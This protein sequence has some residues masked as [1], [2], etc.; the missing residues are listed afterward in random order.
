MGVITKIG[1]KEV[2]ELFPSFSFIKLTLTTE[3]LI[4][5]TYIVEDKC[6]KYIL[7]K[8]ENK[9]EL[10]IQTHLQL[11]KKLSLHNITVPQLI[12]QSYPWFL[13]NYIDGEH[14]TQINYFNLQQIAICIKKIHK[15]TR[16]YS[17]N[18]HIFDRINISNALHHQRKTSFYYYKKYLKLKKMDRSSDGIIHGD[19]FTQNIVISNNNIAIIDFIDA[20][21]GSFSFDLA[22]ALSSLVK[23]PSRQHYIDYF[24]QVYNQT[25]H[26]KIS[27]KTL[28]KKI[29]YAKLFYELLRK[30]LTNSI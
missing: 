15:C 17:I 12:S 30:N 2:Q 18:K 23:H 27:K 11:L 13:Y 29:Q 10:Q 14:P 28:L 3:G 8:Y 21:D 25:N 16:A 22:V 6:K 26:Q 4:D 1:I 7:K 19:I 5:T 20:A 24:L 9:T